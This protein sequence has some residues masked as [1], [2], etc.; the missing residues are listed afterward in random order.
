[1]TRGS[2]QRAV[3]VVPD[4]STDQLGGLSGRMTINIDQA[5]HSYELE[6]TLS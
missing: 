6:Y 5:K 1:M 4:S 2:P 3:T